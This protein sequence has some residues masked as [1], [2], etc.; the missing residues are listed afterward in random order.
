MD[1]VG[2]GAVVAGAVTLSIVA[3]YTVGP[4]MSF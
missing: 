2:D 1:T 3:A 4:E